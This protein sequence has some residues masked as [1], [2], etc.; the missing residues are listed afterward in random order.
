M[1]VGNKTDLAD[2]RY[3]VVSDGSQIVMKIAVGVQRL[4]EID[5]LNEKHCKSGP[6]RTWRYFLTERHPGLL[7]W[8]VRTGKEKIVYVGF[9]VSAVIVRV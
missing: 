3:V 8:R 4:I 9:S 1:L 6:V 7:G 2:K 5:K